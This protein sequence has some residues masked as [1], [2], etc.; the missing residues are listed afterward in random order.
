MNL[1]SY[2]PNGGFMKNMIVVVLLSFLVL[3][4]CASKPAQKCYPKVIILKGVTFDFN[5]SVLRPESHPVL[6]EN[7]TV[8]KSRPKMTVTIVGY[9]DS[10]GNDAYNQKLSEARAN[11]VMQYFLQKGISADRMKAI[12]KGKAD[13]IADNKTDAG[14]AQNRRIEI[15]FTDPEPDVIC[16]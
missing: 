5:K 2:Q 10:D 7:L 14:K 15:E 13:P 6:D 11:A 9:T 3:C 12:G 16:Q 1:H 8:L 4:A